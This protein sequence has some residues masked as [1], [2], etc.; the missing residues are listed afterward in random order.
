MRKA[1]GHSFQ[2]RRF[3]RWYGAILVVIGFPAA[4]M[5]TPWLLS[6]L[7]VHHGWHSR[8]PGFWNLIGLLPLVAGASIAVY[9][10]AAHLFSMPHRFEFRRTPDYL[11]TSGPYRFSRNPL[12]IAEGLMWLGWAAFYGSA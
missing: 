6:R 11:L 10:L 9:C 3:P 1:V 2:K 5:V 12:Y 7:S 4:H 8:M